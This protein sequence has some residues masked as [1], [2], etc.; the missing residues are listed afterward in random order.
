MK[1]RIL[2]ILI[3]TAG[4]PV[5][6]AAQ[7]DYWL[8]KGFEASSSAEK[9]QCFTKS[10]EVEGATIDAYFSRAS[11]ELEIRD[12]EGALNDYTRIIE[13]DSGDAGS[14]YT[15]GFA[16][17]Y[18]LQDYRGALADYSRALGIDP[19][20]TSYLLLAGLL[21]CLLDDYPAAI[22][23]YQKA[24]KNNADRLSTKSEIEFINLMRYNPAN[25]DSRQNLVQ[26]NF[27]PPILFEGLLGLALAYYNTKDL[28]NAKKYLDQAREFKPETMQAGYKLETSGY[29]A[30]LFYQKDGPTFLKMVNDLQ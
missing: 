19:A 28:V 3:I 25:S 11:A 26:C 22:D 16:K 30:C 6:L 23:C 27:Q 8:Q 10:I 9:I 15:R 24:L 7:N 29:A 12:Y 20:N 21:N 2:V 17:Q 1:S 4:I 14:F 13:L 18:Y 5:L